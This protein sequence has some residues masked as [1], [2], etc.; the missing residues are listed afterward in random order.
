MK[1]SKGLNHWALVLVLGVASILLYQHWN[2]AARS[3]Q[4]E[5]AHDLNTEDGL[6]AFAAEVEPGDVLMYSTTHCPHCAQAR[7]WLKRYG[8]DW[9]ECNMS[10]TP[11]CEDEF[12][13]L[14]ADGTP[15]LI[16]RGHHMKNGFDSDE[17]LA[18][19][20]GAARIAGDA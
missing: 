8:F 16:V 10:T 15:Y 17:F 7:S 6:R 13:A 19:L 1:Y 20:R 18:A 5:A 11:H 3:E 12:R 4:I 14:G 2:S 9:T